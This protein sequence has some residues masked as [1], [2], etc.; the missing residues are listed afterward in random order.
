MLLCFFLLC[1]SEA[2]APDGASLQQVE[3]LRQ[4]VQETLQAHSHHLVFETIS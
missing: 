4:E 2:Q 1:L 3:Q